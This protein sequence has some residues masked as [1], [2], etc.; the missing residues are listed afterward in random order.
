MEWTYV[1]TDAGTEVGEGQPG[2]FPLPPPLRARG[3]KY[4]RDT[5]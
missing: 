2:R 4:F 1:C 3:E 5:S